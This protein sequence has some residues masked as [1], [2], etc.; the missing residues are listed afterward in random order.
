VPVNMWCF[1]VDGLG[2]CTDRS[3]VC[4]VQRKFMP[5]G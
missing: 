4:I 3:D 2:I 1:V 5:G